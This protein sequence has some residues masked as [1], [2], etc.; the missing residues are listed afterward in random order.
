[1]FLRKIGSR[2]AILFHLALI[3]RGVKNLHLGWCIC[4]KKL[5]ELRFS[6]RLPYKVLKVQTF[7]YLLPSKDRTFCCMRHESFV[8]VELI[9]GHFYTSKFK[10]LLRLIHH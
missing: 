6:S 7:C 8:L 1:L 3:C 9:L 5:F 2:D 4:T 10:C